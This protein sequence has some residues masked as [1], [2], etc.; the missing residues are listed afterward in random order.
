[1]LNENIQHK[2]K[3]KIEGADGLCYNNGKEE[4]FES[5]RKGKRENDRT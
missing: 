5:L 1:M 3:K 2:K 4:N